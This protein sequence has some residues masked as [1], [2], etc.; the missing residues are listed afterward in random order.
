MVFV[1]NVLSHRSQIVFIQRFSK[2]GFDFLPFSIG[3]LILDKTVSD[4]NLAGII[5][6]APV[7]NGEF[8]LFLATVSVCL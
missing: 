2:R 1:L 7:I 3:G 4:P 5:V 8:V 6:Y